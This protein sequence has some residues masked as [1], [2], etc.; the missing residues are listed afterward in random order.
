MACDWLD[1]TCKAKEFASSALGDAL[2]NTANAVLEAVGKALASLGTIWVNVPTP[3]LTGGG[4]SSGQAAGASAPSAGGVTTVLSYFVW[5]ALGIAILSLMALGAQ[6][7]LA[8]RHHRAERLGRLGWIF[9]S[10]LIV[11]SASAII[12][13]LVPQSN[14][15]GSPAVAY[16]QN[17]MWWYMAAAAVA[18][19]IVGAIKMAW[20]Q[21]AQAGL[22]LVRSLMTLI[23]VSGAG[24]TII[25]LLVAA[26]DGFAV[27]LINGSLDCDVTNT[28]GT[29]FGGN[30]AAMLALTTNPVT[31]G[32]G[33]ILII[34]LGLVA[35]L[36]SIVQIILMLA[37][38][39]MLVVLAGVLPTTAA[40]TNTEMGRSWFKKSLSWL[41]AFI[42][43]K[44]A[45]AIIYAVAFKL[46]GT[47]IFRDDG[48]GLIS[49]LTGLTLMALALVALP[50]LMRFVTPLVGPLAGGGASAAV[51]LGA[52]AALPT[53]A[54]QIGQLLGGGSGGGSSGGGSASTAP[55][56][57]AA[58]S[59]GGPGAGSP[60]GAGAAGAAGS[61]GAS[62]AA[63]A[64]AGGG[65]A[66]G[67]AAA[68]GAA[69][70]AGPVGLAVAAGASAL[71]A[72]GSAAR[73][74]GE[75]STGGPD[76][77]R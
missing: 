20:E 53:G 73:S 47:S 19:V 72:A 8:R 54:A 35:V 61:G 10:V 66:A 42:L 45:A 4:G 3:N 59:A 41:V 15:G 25:G 49:V 51:A 5:I 16:V 39:G 17:S 63:G 11:S 48:T 38:G 33:P 23:V 64:S 67:G 58:G 21:R 36:V 69:A 18:S 13:A 37:R 50:A 32:L 22:D 70:A 7:A 29:C 57:G 24:L 52:A 28:G 14:S 62:G 40:A 71:S 43:Y 60:G 9:A 56:A 27:W 77:S 6:M 2:T 31:G 46:A 76:G 12:A 55:P 65:A 34:V 1:V 68:G 26:A 75:S 74:V 30:M 44:P